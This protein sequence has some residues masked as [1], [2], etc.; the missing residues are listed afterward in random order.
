MMSITQLQKL[1]LLEYIEE[2]RA[3]QKVSE[4]EHS[5]RMI[6]DRNIPE[7]MGPRGTTNYTTSSSESFVPLNFDLYRK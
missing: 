4:Q 3:R 1:Y 2:S 5:S 6:P 7:S